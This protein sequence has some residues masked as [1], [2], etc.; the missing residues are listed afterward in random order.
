MKLWGIRDYR[1]AL[2]MEL[3]RLRAIEGLRVHFAGQDWRRAAPQDLV[4]MLRGGIHMDEALTAVAELTTAPD[5]DIQGA[6]ETD[7]QGD[8][9]DLGQVNGSGQVR[10]PS[11]GRSRRRRGGQRSRGS[12]GSVTDVDT[13]AAALA[14]LAVNPGIT[15][16]SLGEQIGVTESYACRLKNKLLPGPNRNNGSAVQ[17][18]P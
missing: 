2:A 17:R 10:L 1:G 5:T 8:R 7:V 4:W 11:S 3:A 14:I 6:P 16:K 13:E 9:T 12:S 15:G 18:N